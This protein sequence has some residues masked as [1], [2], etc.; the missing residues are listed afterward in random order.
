MNFDNVIIGCGP[1]GAY[2]SLLLE[3]NGFKTAIVEE[4]SKIGKPISCAGLV[5][6]KGLK[7]LGLKI[8]NNCIINKTKGAYI[9][10]PDYT[11]VEAYKNARA[12]KVV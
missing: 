7:E 6:I 9:F 4:H 1:V 3:K 8:P 2:T 12:R 10:S 5:S 11:K